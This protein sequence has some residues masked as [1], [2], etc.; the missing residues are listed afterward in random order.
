MKTHPNWPYI[1]NSGDTF[2]IPPKM[3]L[4]KAR[5][6]GDKIYTAGID[7]SIRVWDKHTGDLLYEI[8]GHKATISGMDISSESDQMVTV[9]LKG[10][11]KF[12]EI[13]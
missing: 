5:F 4:T 11:I 2:Y 12:S 6:A 10:G 9:D 1:L 3:D 8:L 7:R 13:D